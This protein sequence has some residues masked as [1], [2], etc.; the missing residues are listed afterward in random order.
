MSCCYRVAV[1]SSRQIGGGYYLLLICQ[2]KLSVTGKLLLCPAEILLNSPV[3]C[4]TL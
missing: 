4:V 2:E 1:I 3:V